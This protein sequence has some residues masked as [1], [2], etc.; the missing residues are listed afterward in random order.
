MLDALVPVALLVGL[1]YVLRATAFMPEAAWAPIDRLVYFVLFPCLLFRE[2]AGAELG[3]I[4]MARMAACLL[5]VQLAMALLARL[6]RSWFSLDGPSYT[7]V[8]QCV[9][10]WNS[11]VALAMAP[12]LAPGEGV[13][14]IAL[15]VAVMVPT[16]NLLSVAALA[17]HGTARASGPGSFARAVASN[18]LIVATLAGVLANLLPIP[19]PSFVMEP[20]GVAG[21]AALALGL[22]TV[23]AGLRVNVAVTRPGLTLT[24]TAAQLLVKPLLAACASLLFGLGGP[25]QIVA[26][27]AC[28]V[29]TATSSYILA[30]L[31]GGNADLMAVL[32]TSTTVAALVTMP[33]VIRLLGS[34]W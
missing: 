18:P 9:V 24:A 5:T 29:P 12:I 2:I 33:L 20:I 15:S 10:R 28:A 8:L 16:A 1:G 22:L 13:P 4:P 21:R 19:L 14:L 17:R 3:E 30:R 34:S 26:L 31:L 11:Y 25:A 27:L 7:S 32:V 23:G 6:I